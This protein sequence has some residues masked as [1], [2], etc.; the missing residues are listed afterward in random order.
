MAFKHKIYSTSLIR[1]IQNKAVIHKIKNTDT[2][3]LYWE[4]GGKTDFII[5]AGGR[6][7][8]YSLY[9]G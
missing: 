8:R 6:I 2:G 4:K 9:A 3:I 5:L 7:N 1:E